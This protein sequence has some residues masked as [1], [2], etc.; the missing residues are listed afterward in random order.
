MLAL[1]LS[2]EIESRLNNLAKKT[3][4]T[5]S[6]YARE[7]I[8]DYLDNQEDINLAEKRLENVRAGRSRTFTLEEV[9]QKLDL[10]D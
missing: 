5:K 2:D 8:V 9:E 10:E 7:A 3:G 4:R 1:R 6:F